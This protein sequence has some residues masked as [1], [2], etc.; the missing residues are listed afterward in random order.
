MNTYTSSVSQTYTISVEATDEDEAYKLVYDKMQSADDWE[1]LFVEAEC[2]NCGET[3][4]LVEC[5][6]DY[7]TVCPKGC[8]IAV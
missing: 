6:E 7:F 1:V 4:E 2:V 3:P 8:F 5:G